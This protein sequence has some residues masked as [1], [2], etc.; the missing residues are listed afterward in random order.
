[1]DP[2]TNRIPMMVPIKGTLYEITLQQAEEVYQMGR[3]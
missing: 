2:S 1:V 3:R